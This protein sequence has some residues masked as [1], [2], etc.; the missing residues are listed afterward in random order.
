MAFQT[1]EKFK[2]RILTSGLAS[3]N[4]FEV[5]ITKIPA[6]GLRFKNV[7]QDISLMCETV[8]IAG[9][10][11][12]STLDTTYGYRREIPYNAPTYNPVTLTFLC[13]E[14]LKE[15]VFFDK[16]NDRVVSQRG[17]FDNEYYDNIVGT[18]EVKTL[19]RTNSD[20]NNYIITYNEV[21]PK[22]VSSVE[23]NHSTQNAT[24]RVNVEMAYSYWTTGGSG[25]E[26]ME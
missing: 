18:M 4:K 12:Q 23:F 5:S 17:G 1:I 24:L 22:T 8:S 25:V 20:T 3:P 2:S 7:L 6:M 16:W 9:R 14:G 19:N 11:V 13:S 10:T 15:K 26:N 21:Y